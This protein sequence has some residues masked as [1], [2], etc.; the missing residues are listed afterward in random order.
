MRPMRLID[1]CSYKYQFVLVSC[2]TKMTIAKI[3]SIKHYVVLSVIC[4]E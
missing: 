4:R 3:L 1:F 2:R